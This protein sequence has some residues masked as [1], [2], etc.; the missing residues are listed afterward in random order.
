MLICILVKEVV[1]KE[2]Q[3]CQALL[4][5]LTKPETLLSTLINFSVNP[6]FLLQPVCML[7]QKK[8][9]FDSHFFFLLHRIDLL[10]PACFSQTL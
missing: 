10:N 7:T 4:I 6:G 5:G 9:A 8:G 2:V 1:V 3:H